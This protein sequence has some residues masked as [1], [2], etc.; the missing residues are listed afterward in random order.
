MR[1]PS[2]ARVLLLA[3]ITGG[4]DVDFERVL[5]EAEARERDAS[6]DTDADGGT[7]DADTDDDGL[8]L[9]D[10]DVPD[11]DIPD[12]DVPDPDLPDPGFP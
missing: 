11:P 3:V 8:E 1:L 5:R 9:P 2:L 4:C 6:F 12:P 10:P 7:E